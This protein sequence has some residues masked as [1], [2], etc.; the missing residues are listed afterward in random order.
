MCPDDENELNV[1]LL[2]GD[3]NGE[4]TELEAGSLQKTI[5]LSGMYQNWFLDYASY[6]ILERAVPDVKDGLKPVHRRIL[7][8]LNELDDGRYNKVANIIGHTMKYHPHGDA[9]IGDALVQLGQ[10]E[11]LIDMQGNWGNIHT[12]DSAAAPRYIEARLS[13]FANEVVFNPK[14]TEWKLS[15]D[16]RNKEPVAL[17]VKFPLLLA[18]GVEG[19]AVGLSSKILP[20]NFNELIDASINI[21][22]K[23]DFEILPD[24]LTGGLMDATKYNDGH[25]G[26][27]VRLRAKISQIDKKTLLISEIPFGTTTSSLI[28]TIILA[29]EKGKIKIRKIDDNTSQN[30]EILVHLIP[31]VSPDTTMD[32]LYA[33]TACEI[34]ISPNCCV[35][36]DGKPRFI[37][38][39][40]VLRISTQNTVDLL[41]Q[42]LLIRKAELEENWHFSS[43]EKIFIENRIYRDIEECETWEAVI[44]NID[45]GLTP[46]KPLFRR[47][48][49]TD[50]I[51]RLTEIKIKRISKFDSF[52]ADELIRNIEDEIE[53]VK[54]HLDNLIDY[55]INYFKQ[56]KKKYGKN[57]DRRTE[58][59]NFENI[60]ATLVAAANEKLYVNKA[61]G[62]IG[63][64]LKKDE[65]VC[66]CSDIDDVITFRSDGTFKVTKVEDKVFVGENI[67]HVDIFK[68]NDERTIYNMIYQDGVQGNIMVKRFAVLGVTRDKEYVLTKGSKG[69]RVLYFTANPNGE[70]E[71]VKVD[72][73]PKPKLKKLTFEFD[74]SSIEIKG[75]NSMGNI[76]TR[77]AVRRIELKDAGV[78]TLAARD[79]WFDDTVLRLNSDGRGTH[80]GAFEGNDKI[81]TFTDKAFMKF[82]NFD[83]NAHF[84]EDMKTI[85]K[86]NPNKPFSF[87]YKDNKTSKYFVKRFLPEPSDKRF[88]VVGIESGAVLIA[89]T[90]DHLPRIEVEYLLAKTQEKKTEIINLFDFVEIMNQKA[91]GK[92][93]PFDAI[94]KVRLIDSLPY[95]EPLKE[96]SPE[97]ENE[98]VNVAEQNDEPVSFTINPKIIVN[99]DEDKGKPI[100]PSDIQQMTLDFL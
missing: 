29:N 10:K 38:V 6:V 2:I 56:I 84:D 80:I 14:T 86:F 71:I 8:A 49:T 70:A 55:V 41:Q 48:I 67:L 63:T 85:E 25:R 90:S 64:G 32:A 28:D 43:L 47:E 53:E 7:H 18:Q 57:R 74:F 36:H 98:E 100:N 4:Y 60:E 11:I 72:H 96:E 45:K 22:E 69:S 95:D 37:T 65:F 93:I 23:K 54:N 68:K 21:L 27:K 59:R 5:H 15:Y 73:K 92:R 1:P 19:I 58:I 26:G 33:F 50:D 12:G 3:E 20:H 17:P 51:V 66:D 46:F 35:I 78:S 77:N 40:E 61:E 94:K 79:I 81:I 75:R 34:S 97:P 89:M 87:V 91:R 82:Y 42:E 13:K 83:L 99:E 44:E 76:L 30:V 39:S 88:D 31:G 9:S 52:K 62:F 24:F 16:G